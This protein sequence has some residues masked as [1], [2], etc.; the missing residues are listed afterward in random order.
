MNEIGERIRYGEYLERIMTAD[1]PQTIRQYEGKQFVMFLG[2]LPVEWGAKDSG[3][4]VMVA[5]TIFRLTP[6]AGCV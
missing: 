4:A 2:R 6:E 1:A 3:S 5:I